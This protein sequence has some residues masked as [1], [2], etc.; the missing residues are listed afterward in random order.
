MFGTQ[1]MTQMS[2]NFVRYYNYVFCNFTLSIEYRTGIWVMTQIP[3]IIL[4][5]K[6]PAY[7]YLVQ[8]T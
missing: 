4:Q 1:A 5:R 3:E 8:L 2:D 6:P 7:V